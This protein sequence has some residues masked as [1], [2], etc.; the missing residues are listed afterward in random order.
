MRS[1]PRAGRAS[2]DPAVRDAREVVGMYGDPDTT[3][4]I[5]AE[6]TLDASTR[7]DDAAVA[8]RLRRL[9]AREPHLGAVP[10]LERPG[11]DGW[12]GLRADLA[13]RPYGP[14][15]PLLR[16]GRDDEGRRLVV[17][18]HHGV[19]DGLGLLAVAG[20]ALGIEVRSAARGIG[21]RA[22]PRG[23]LR[24]SAR[25]VG[26]ALVSPPPRFPGTGEPGALVEDLSTRAGSRLGVGSSALAAAV[27]AA[28]S[29]RA[30]PGSAPAVLVVGASR[31]TADLPRPDR[32]TAY[33]RLRLGP[34]VTAST[35]GGL[36]AATPPEPD[37]P[38]TSARGVG[39][40]LVRVLRHRLGAT[41]MLS[42]LGVVS[43]PGIESVVMF[44]ASS[45]PRA[46]AV[47]LA[48][49]A[50]TTTLSLRTRRRDFTAAEHTA[51]LDAV[52]AGLWPSGVQTGQ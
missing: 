36:L 17:G 40:R 4:G 7:V 12:T 43:G 20:A 23:F 29:D 38:E 24:S 41:A 3:W 14:T 30:A 11:A 18:A 39:P 10:A 22:A 35:I 13:S 31:R 6:V 47:G 9:C 5:C 44:P 51:L 33:L 21:D 15:S 52:S 50:A 2:V 1:A 48:S 27:L 45:G 34:V 26:E 25:R 37:F 19:I 32:Q 8:D 16:V 46:V 49:T 28:W 42:N